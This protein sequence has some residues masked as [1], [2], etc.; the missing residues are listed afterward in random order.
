MSARRRKRCW[1]RCCASSGRRTRKSWRTPLSSARDTQRG[2][3][4][5]RHRRSPAAGAPP[6]PGAAGPAQAPGAA[7]PAQAPGGDAAAQAPG[8]DNTAAPFTDVRLLRRVQGMTSELVAALVPLTTVFG[9]DTVNPMTAPANVLAALPGMDRDRAAAIIETRRNF[10]SDAA[11]LQPLLGPMQKYLQV[12]PQ[13]AV[14]VA[15]AASVAD[16]YQ[17]AANAVIIRLSGDNEPYRVL[18][19]SPSPRS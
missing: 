13:R 19:W 3:A 15:V 14:S 6:S 16:G 11:R 8:A 1:S 7:P 4:A 17:A 2:V 12:K 5:R 18:A 10:P 9:S